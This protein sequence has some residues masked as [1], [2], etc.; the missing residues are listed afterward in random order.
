MGLL[1]NSRFEDVGVG[2]WTENADSR[3]FYIAR[4]TRQPVTA[5]IATVFRPTPTATWLLSIHV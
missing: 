1:S 3:D 5:A 2:I 4:P